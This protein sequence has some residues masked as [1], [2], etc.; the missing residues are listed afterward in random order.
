[1]RLESVW[2]QFI[3][4]CQDGTLQRRSLQTISNY[5]SSFELF[6]KLTA[7]DELMDINEPAL[8]QF[9]RIGETD[10]KW[11]PN[12]SLTH[13]KNLQPF[14][15]WCEIKGYLSTDP[16]ANIPR[17]KILKRLPEYFSDVEIEQILY[18]TDIGAKNDF[19]RS[20]NLGMLA[21]LIMAG[22]RS[23]ELLGLQLRDIDFEHKHIRVRAENAKDAEDRAIPL[24]RRL[25]D[26]I[27]RYT[28]LRNARKPKYMAL[29]L[30]EHGKPFT[31]HGWD[32]FIKNLEKQVGFEIWTHKFRHTFATNY[33]RATRDVI[34]LQQILGHKD[35]NTTMIYAHVAP[36]NL[37]A[38][39]EANPL[40]HLF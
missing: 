24:N 31:Q 36:E 8:R 11:K 7:V 18:Q 35:I 23:G 6:T 1:M 13:R 2:E 5:R 29:W 19:L 9:I 4:E 25:V 26:Q 30:S 3:R 27:S 32:H 37:R 15:K 40:A 38:S 28:Q 33:Y 21:T 34:G 16:F 20:R 10:R 22:L 39:I 17:P 14:T 12:T